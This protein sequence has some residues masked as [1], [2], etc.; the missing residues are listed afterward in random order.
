MRVNIHPEPIGN[1]DINLPYIS[2]VYLGNYVRKFQNLGTTDITLVNNGE[3]SLRLYAAQSFLEQHGIKTKLDLLP[4]RYHGPDQLFN[5]QRYTTM[6]GAVPG[7]QKLVEYYLTVYK[8]LEENVNQLANADIFYGFKKANHLHW[9]Q[10]GLAMPDTTC[11]MH[12]QIRELC[13]RVFWSYV[14]LLG[15][16][17]GYTKE[18]ISDRLLLR[19]NH[20]RPGHYRDPIKKIFIGGHWDTSVIT[21]SLYTSHPGQTIQVN[22]KMTPVEQF[23]GQE[24]EIL[25]IPGMD[26]CD[27]FNTM[28][29]PTWHEVVDSCDNQDR[30]SIVAFLKRRRFRE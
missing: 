10:Y 29:E 18:D 1:F 8:H 6:P 27:E 24:Q 12:Q 28:V 30:V 2:A 9:Y 3:P 14:Q 21:G 20:T 11:T 23:Y 17:L 22:D 19:L 7:C 13:D 5:G 26:Y 25:L 15:N 16:F 4:A